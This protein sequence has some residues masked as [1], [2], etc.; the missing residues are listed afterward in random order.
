MEKKTILITGATGFL[1]FRT[2]ERYA[3][4]PSVMKIIA[5]GRS[6]K[7]GMI[8][9]HNLVE[10]ILGDL[11]NPEFVNT[12][13]KGVDIIIHC[14]ALSSPWGTKEEFRLANLVPQE[15]LIQAAEREKV[16]RFV[17]ISTPS[18]YFNFK[19]RTNIKESDPLPNPLVNNYAS[20]KRDAELL[21]EKSQLN[22]VI[23]RPRALTGRGDTVIMPRL[24][25]AYEEGRLKI[26][27]N[28]KNK[29]D[30]TAVSNVVDA[31]QLSIEAEGEAVNQTYNISNGEPVYLWDSVRTVLDRLNMKF[32]SKKIPYGLVYLVASSMESKARKHPEKGEPVLTKYSVGILAKTFTMDIS[33]AKRLLNY[34]PKMNTAE[35]IDEFTNWYKKD[36]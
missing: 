1:G 31:I 10:Y 22:F 34:T 5:T 21:L 7:P 28:G 11:T 9:D 18:L 4:D 25:R 12:I 24:I 32:S 6:K 33:K 15:L 20:T 16:E 13:A 14:A 36:A 29:V 3:K 26:V 17:F 30:L 2:L 8:V 35:A 23:L 27:G 19:N